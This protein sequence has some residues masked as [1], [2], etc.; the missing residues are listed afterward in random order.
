MQ[1]KNNPE[2]TLTLEEI[3]Q[4][5]VE[6]IDKNIPEKVDNIS[7]QVNFKLEDIGVDDDDRVAYRPN[8]Q[9]NSAT[10]KLKFLA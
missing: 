1:I 2:V 7:T 9:L 10:V 4:A 6:Y 3:E 8:F 5:I